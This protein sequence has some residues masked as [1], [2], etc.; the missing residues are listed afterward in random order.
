MPNFSEA[1]AKAKRFAGELLS[2]PYVTYP[3][4]G[5]AGI[6]AGAAIG[7]IAAMPN[8]DERYTQAYNQIQSMVGDSF[9]PE[10][11]DYE[12]QR[13]LY[14]HRGDMTPLMEGGNWEEFAQKQQAM[15]GAMPLDSTG[16][17]VGYM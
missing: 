16:T 2:K 13:I 12:T 11:I 14:D 7:K 6:G 10:D 8:E 5:A 4:A 3:V 15:A 9:S 17:E 1:G